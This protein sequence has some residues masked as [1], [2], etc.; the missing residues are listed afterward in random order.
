MPDPAFLVE[1]H[2]EQRIIQRLCPGK[3]VRLIGC[4]GDGVSMAAVAKALNVHM[5][6]MQRFDPIIIVLDRERRTE[7]CDLLMASLS[8]A[9]DEYGYQGRYI[10]GMSDRTIKNWILSD[11]AN[12]LTHHPNCSALEVDAEGCHGKSV[13]RK[14]MSRHVIYHE[15]TIGVELFLRCRAT[16]LFSNSA[17]FRDFV[18]KVK[19]ECWWLKDINPDFE[20]SSWL[21]PN[22]GI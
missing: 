20:A 9:M 14:L 4:N 16:H 2:M 12:V 18:S 19:I 8:A 21:E 3:T 1:G 6:T 7:T 5:R 22:L 13:I 10:I 17:S 15:T 11:W